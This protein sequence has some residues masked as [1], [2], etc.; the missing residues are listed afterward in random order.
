MRWVVQGVAPGKAGGGGGGGGRTRELMRSLPARAVTMALWAPDTHGPWS[1][2]RMTHLPGKGGA[3]GGG[4]GGGG[5][6][7]R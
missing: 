4:G 7:R 5:G 1:A 3:G 6:V 2:H